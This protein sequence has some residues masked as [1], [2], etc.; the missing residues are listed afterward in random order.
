VKSPLFTANALE[1]IHQAAAGI[2]RTIGTIA[3]V[4]RQLEFPGNDN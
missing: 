2:L 3:T 4:Q 1:L